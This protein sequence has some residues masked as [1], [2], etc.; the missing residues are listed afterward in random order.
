MTTSKVLVISSFTGDNANVIRDFLFAFNT[1]SKHEYH[2]VFDPSLL[3]EEFEFGAYDII[4]LFWSLYLLAPTLPY[5][6]RDR[7]REARGLKV[8]MLQDEYRDVRAFNEVMAQLGVQVMLTCVAPADHETFYPKSLIPSLKAVHTVL[9]GYVPRYLEGQAPDLTT[10]RALDVAYRS[11][12]VPYWLGDLGQEKCR[13]AD[14][15]GKTAREHGLKVDISV[16]ET[17]RIYGDAWVKFLA[18]A[19]CTLGT[20]SGASVVDFDGSLKRNVE[21]MLTFKPDTSYDEVRSALLAPYEGK[22]GVR[23]ISPRMFESAALGNTLICHKGGY[24]G[25]LVADRH[26]IPVEL[27]HSNTAEV[28]ERVR[29]IGHCRKLAQ[30]CWDDLIASGAYSYRTFVQWF[31]GM[32]ADH[33]PAVAARG[34]RSRSAHTWDMYWRGQTMVPRG[35]DVVRLPSVRA[36]IGRVEA[37]LQRASHRL[38]LPNSVARILKDPRVYAGKALAA[39]WVGLTEPALRRLWMAFFK[40]R[41]SLMHVRLDQLAEDVTKL[42]ILRQLSASGGPHFTMRSEP[43]QGRLM[44]ETV[45]SAPEGA[46]TGRPLL[47]LVGDATPTRLYWDHSQV[48]AYAKLSVAGGMSL[49]FHV[50]PSGLHVFEAL[51]A[52]ATVDE[53]A[54]AAALEPVLTRANQAITA[55]AMPA[56]RVGSATP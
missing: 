2:Y 49:E 31:D 1:H 54:V 23:A 22:V 21:R 15:F 39:G 20:E 17:D 42:A 5:P 51:S 35:D 50:G 47:R 16:K 30:N 41:R 46:T 40:N 9:T 10:P 45:T 53:A 13:I 19:R 29:D 8:L 55:D 27:D 18:S 24:S 12:A 3:D 11:R 26:Y 56:P 14:W 32:L 7:I 28:I 43:A 36:A 38:P 25:A 33:L 52:L 37:A 6:V 34:S 4:L 44:I 48:G